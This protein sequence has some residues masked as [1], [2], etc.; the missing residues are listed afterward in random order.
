MRDQPQSV[1]APDVCIPSGFTPDTS[2]TLFSLDSRIGLATYSEALTA[3][4]IRSTVS[5]LPPWWQLDAL[6]CTS[7]EHHHIP[8]ATT[9]PEHL[10]VAVELVRQLTPQLILVDID[11]GYTLAEALHQKHVAL[12]PYWYIIE[13]YTSHRT[14]TLPGV[15]S[16]HEFHLS[17]GIPVAYQCPHDLSHFHLTT[18]TE[19]DGDHLHI[20]HP[21]GGVRVPCIH[22]PY[23]LQEE[24]CRHL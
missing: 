21:K 16:I 12:P 22:L 10:P 3:L 24:S 18:Q 23:P 19:K 6:V 17:P 2:S 9:H 7:H 14:F 1:C 20:R 13:P 8:H 5:L 11:T 4:S 15:T